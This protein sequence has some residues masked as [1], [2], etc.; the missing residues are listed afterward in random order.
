MIFIEGPVLLQYRVMVAVR[1]VEDRYHLLK[2]GS[3]DERH[4]PAKTLQLVDRRPLRIIQLL[5]HEFAR[6][7]VF[8]PSVIVHCGYLSFQLNQSLPGYEDD[9]LRIVNMRAFRKKR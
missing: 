9:F 3:P 1:I 6:L 7:F 5:H 4:T 2:Q 8:Y